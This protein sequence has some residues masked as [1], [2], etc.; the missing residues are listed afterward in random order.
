MP[1]GRQLGAEPER[2]DD[3]R[4]VAGQRRAEAQLRAAHRVQE[5]E[6][7]GG[8]QQAVTAVA[9]AEQPVVSALP[10]AGVADDRVAGVL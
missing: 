6:L 1:T 10:V 3:R 7:D 8:E 2:V 9:L 5:L 4:E